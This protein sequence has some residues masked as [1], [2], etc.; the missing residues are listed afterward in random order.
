MTTIPFA[1]QRL[2]PINFT[3][4]DVVRPARG[5][6]LHI[7]EGSYDGTIGWARNP[8]AQV[9]YYA[10][11]AQDGRVAQVVDLDDKA[12]TQGHGNAEW[13]GVEFEGH[14]PGALTAAQIETAAKLL[15][16]FHTLYGIPLVATDDPV[17]GRG[18]GWHGMG[19]HV[20]WGHPLCPGPA[21]VAQRPQIIARAIALV[22]G[23]APAPKPEP[24][25]EPPVPP[26]QAPT[27]DH[28]DD[29][30]KTTDIKGIHLDTKGEGEIAIKGVAE[31]A[32]V[33]TVV[34]GGSDA[35]AVK[36]YDKTPIT[37]V[38]AGSNPALIVIEG[39][40]PKGVYTV[41]VSHA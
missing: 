19:A 14:T 26:T 2:T 20:G 21:V 31:S 12:W 5:M 24:K 6:V 35:N 18:L 34:I 8:A 10:V 25:P 30:V 33:A 17:N 27:I 39:G 29:N 23:S 3:N 9:S 22:G 38:V 41:R 4:G 13:L 1:E 28:G 32:I 7:A 36:R 40:E 11:V 16:F 15:A 37:R